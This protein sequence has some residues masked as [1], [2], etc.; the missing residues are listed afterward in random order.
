MKKKHCFLA[1]LTFLISFFASAQDITVINHYSDTTGLGNNASFFL[2]NSMQHT[3]LINYYEPFPHEEAGRLENLIGNALS[4]YVDR[5]IEVKDDNIL[6]AKTKKTIFKELNSIVREGIKYYNYNPLNEFSGFSEQVKKQIEVL[7]TLDFNSISQSLEK[8]KYYYIQ[9]E[10]NDLKLLLNIEIGNI[11]NNDMFHVSNVIHSA[12]LPNDQEELLNEIENLQI[13]APLENLDVAMS[14]QIKDILAQVDDESSAA[15]SG[16]YDL[17]YSMIKRNSVIL[18]SLQKQISNSSL[19]QNLNYQNQIDELRA[20]IYDLI[21]K[22]QS[23]NGGELVPNLPQIITTIF[24]KGQSSLTL[25]QQFVLNELI[26]LLAY[27][28]RLKIVIT[29]YT[30]K[31]GSY[32]SNWALSKKRA[33][34]VRQFLLNRGIDDNRMILNFYGEKF[35]TNSAEKDRKVEIEFFVY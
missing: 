2:T 1:L 17:L 18:D 35:A 3:L 7:F 33:L 8:N 11:K 32:S 31:S 4:F 28:P 15:A 26:D 22:G 34:S 9:K 13:N 23:S 19:N 14:D 25:G 30:D 6:I 12:I 20:T 27:N 21:K 10:L 29:G 16:D 24:A 5:L